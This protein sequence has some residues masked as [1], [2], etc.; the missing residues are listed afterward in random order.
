MLYNACLIYAF[1]TKASSNAFPF[2]IFQKIHGAKLL[3]LFTLFPLETSDGGIQSCNIIVIEIWLYPSAS[4]LLRLKF[5]YFGYHE[6]RDTITKVHDTVPAV[7]GTET[8]TT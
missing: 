8:N 7:C 5:I 3:L 2:L 4:Q 6:Q 1:Q